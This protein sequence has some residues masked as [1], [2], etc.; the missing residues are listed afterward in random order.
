MKTSLRFPYNRFFGTLANQYRID[1]IEI[2]KKG[3]KN[4]SEICETLGHHQSTISHNLRRLQECGFVHVKPNGRERVYE[5]NQK[6]IAPLF[7]L[8]QIHMNYY[9]KK[10]RGCN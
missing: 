2:L 3:P 7:E 1:I 6:T 9:C 10:L 8:M 4:V 5:L